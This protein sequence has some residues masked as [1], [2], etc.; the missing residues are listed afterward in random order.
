M[1]KPMRDGAQ[2]PVDFP[3]HMGGLGFPSSL[4]PGKC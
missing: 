1:V 4:M 3:V 2:I